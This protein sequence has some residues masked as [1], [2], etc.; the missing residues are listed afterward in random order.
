MHKNTFKYVNGFIYVR[1]FTYFFFFVNRAVHG[2]VVQ[3][4]EN[5]N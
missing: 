2:I 3:L 1:I 4:N 5:Y